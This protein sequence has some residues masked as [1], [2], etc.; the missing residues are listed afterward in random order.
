MNFLFQFLKLAILFR[1]LL[2]CCFGILFFSIE[3]K[4]QDNLTDS[5]DKYNDTILTNKTDDS[6]GYAFDWKERE[7]DAYVRNRLELHVSSD[8]S[9]QKLKASKEFWYVKSIETFTKNAYRIRHDKKYRDSLQKE[10]L[11]PPDAQ[12]F[13]EEQTSDVWYLQTWFINVVWTLIIAVFLA[14]IAYFLSSKKISLFRRNQAKRNRDEA[15]QENFIPPN[16]TALLAESESGK[17]YRVAIRILY[18][19]SLKWLGEKNIISFHPSFTNTHYLL[20][21]QNTHF[22]NGFSIVTRHYEWA[23]YGE[24]AVSETLYQKIK[25]DFINLTNEALQ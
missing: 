8:T 18:L 16:Y 19:Q 22:Y 3:I 1:L 10:G 20:Q 2:S 23:W 24:F 9:V 7:A 25:T 21:L 12:V 15:T 5:I 13:T 6:I 14:A 4:A 11:L 17:D